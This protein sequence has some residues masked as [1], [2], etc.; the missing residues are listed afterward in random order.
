MT[1]VVVIL[2]G[3]F[4]A[5]FGPWFLKLTKIDSRLANGLA[6]G[7]ASHG[8]GTAKALEIGALEGAAGGLAIA[9]MGVFTSVLVPIAVPLIKILMLKL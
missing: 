9:L 3:I 1:A 6:L 2:S 4:G 8:I 5:V 7:S